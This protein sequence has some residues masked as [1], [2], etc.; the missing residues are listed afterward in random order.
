ML[1]QPESV[2]PTQ[3]W[4]A[5]DSC[6]LSLSRPTVPQIPLDNKQVAHCTLFNAVQRPFQLDLGF[7]HHLRTI[8]DNRVT[9]AQLC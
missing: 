3:K 9:R 2:K 1:L 8:V 4:P 6:A 7:V 5:G